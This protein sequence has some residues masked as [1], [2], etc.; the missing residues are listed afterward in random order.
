MEIDSALIPV[1][2]RKPRKERKMSLI[3]LDKLYSLLQKSKKRLRELREQT[4]DIT[5]YHTHLSHCYVQSCMDLQWGSPVPMNVLRTMHENLKT[6]L[7]DIVI[8]LDV[9]RRKIKAK[10]RQRKQLRRILLT[11]VDDDE[12]L[13]EESDD[14]E[15]NLNDDGLLTTETE[16]DEESDEQA[17]EGESILPDSYNG[18]HTEE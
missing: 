10:E 5:S 4:A 18:I 3:C 7:K 14:S 17:D 8:I 1:A 16:S 15:Y 6:Q 13:E 2:S 9:L 12:D 11:E